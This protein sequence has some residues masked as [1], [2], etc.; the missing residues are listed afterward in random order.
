MTGEGIAELKEH[1]V[2]AS[3]ISP[4]RSARG[5]FRL[6][7]DRS[8][9]LVGAGTVVTGT[10]LSGEISVGDRV[11]VSPS[12]LSARVRSIHAQNR[13]CERGCAGE[14]CRSILP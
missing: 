14:R 1:L 2:E 9:N 12:G 8:F 3:R 6:A 5:R 10:V 11:V 13:P 7:V 4:R